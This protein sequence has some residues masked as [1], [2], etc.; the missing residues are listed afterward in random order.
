MSKSL[1]RTVLATLLAFTLLAVLATAVSIVMM[2]YFTEEA[3]FEETLVSKARTSAEMLEPCSFNERLELLRDQFP[4]PER[5]T[6]ITSEGVV[7]FDTAMQDAPMGDHS[8]RPEVLAAEGSGES[9]VVRRSQTLDRDTLYVAE[10]LSDG[11]IIRV[12]QDRFSLAAFL[13][14]AALPVGA[15]LACAAALVVVLSRFL[16]KRIM[17]PL[18][19]INLNDPMPIDAY[20][21]M[22]PLLQR[23]SDQQRQLMQQN[24]ELK[25]AD[26]LRREF[27]SNVS[28][29]MKTPLQVISGSA[30][31]I[32]N[33][34]VAKDDVQGFG[35]RIYSES[36]RLRALI[37]DVLV[38]SRLDES[39]LDARESTPVSLL[40]IGQ[41]KCDQLRPLAQARGLRLS[42]DG[43]NAVVFG[44]ESLIEQAVSNLVENAIRYSNDGGCIQVEVGQCE[45]D[46]ADWAFVRVEDEGIGIPEAD[47]NKVFERFYRADKSRSKET[48]GTGLGLAIVKHAALYHGGD[49]SVESALGEG[50]TFT[51]WLPVQPAG[52]L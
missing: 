9:V 17:R 48:G 41:V 43:T 45:R 13:G 8:E 1:S 18:Q 46:D 22:R 4:G 12:S 29:E 37:N 15:L 6:Y 44:S 16:A 31:M 52:T 26:G 36:Q 47:L 51:L 50:S 19:K 40:D 11:S 24:E 38:L 20:E 7:A 35:E 14:T 49:V 3:R 30:E 33:G 5:F 28:H 23:I 21:E 39:S 32:A 25:R 42:L 27:S 34:F 2:S 10:R